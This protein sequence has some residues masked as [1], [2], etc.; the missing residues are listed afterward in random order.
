M[1]NY[2]PG[3]TG[4]EPEITGE[5]PCRACGGEGGYK[6]EE[7]AVACYWCKGHGI[8]PEEVT[9][10]QLWQLS[11]YHGFK[12]AREYVFQMATE[13]LERYDPETRK[14]LRRCMAAVSRRY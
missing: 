9:P 7:E 10:D 2:P 8:E 3:V 5:W 13:W 12:E 4:N 6:D 14:Y 11:R 1:S